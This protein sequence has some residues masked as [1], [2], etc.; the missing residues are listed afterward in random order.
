MIDDPNQYSKVII[1]PQ[2]CHLVKHN[3]LFRLETF[4]AVNFK[5]ETE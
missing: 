1:D 3:K 4:E 5:L 2:T